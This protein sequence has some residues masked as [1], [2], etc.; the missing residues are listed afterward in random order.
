MPRRRKIVLKPFCYYCNRIFEDEAVLLNHQRARHFKCTLC[1]KKTQNVPGLRT[2][3]ERQH[4]QTLTRVPHSLKSRGSDAHLKVV[5]M[6][7]V[8]GDIKHPL[9]DGSLRIRRR[10]GGFDPSTMQ[11][12]L[13]LLQN[14]QVMPSQTVQAA[15]L[16]LSVVAPA[17]SAVMAQK[18]SETVPTY[19]AIPESKEEKCVLLYGDL[20]M[21]MEERK[22]QLPKYRVRVSMQS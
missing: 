15:P 18:I 14:T 20:H 4:H 17:P 21:S 9:D 2:H 8:P 10:V 13:N 6:D 3:Y 5:G 12:P 16:N 1:R 7:G 11:L 19:V 22:S